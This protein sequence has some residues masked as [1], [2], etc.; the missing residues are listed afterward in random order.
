MIVAALVGVLLAGILTAS[1][2]PLYRPLVSKEKQPGAYGALQFG[3]SA[4]ALAA[5]VI[6]ALSPFPIFAAVFAGIL[7]VILLG[8]YHWVQRKDAA[9]LQALPCAKLHH[10]H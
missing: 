8:A 4:A 6:S 5:L 3:A 2:L 9:A 7:A 10:D 1:S